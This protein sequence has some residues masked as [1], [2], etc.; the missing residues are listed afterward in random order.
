[1]SIYIS[2]KAMPYVY[3][4]INNLTKQF[5]IGS[6]YKNVKLNLP[7]HEDLPKYKTSSKIIKPIFSDF[8]W[9]ILA[10]FFNENDAYDFEQQLIF[11][12]W[13]NPLILNENCFYNK[14][15]FKASPVMSKSHKENISKKLRIIKSNVSDETR[16]KLSS[17][18][19]GRVFSEEHRRKISESMRGIIR[20]VETREKMSNSKKKNSKKST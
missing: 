5:Y 20:S 6:R 1:M 9:Y 13:D 3:I 10:E 16:E 2:S 14:K 18:H 19:K 4:G 7:S 8:T 15:R 17:S 12:N 11:E